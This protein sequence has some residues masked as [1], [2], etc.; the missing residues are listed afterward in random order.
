MTSS[1][2]TISLLFVPLSG[3]AR[4]GFCICFGLSLHCDF[5]R[6]DAQGTSLFCSSDGFGRK[7]LK[8]A[9]PKSDFA[10]QICPDK[11]YCMQT[12][13]SP[14]LPIHQAWWQPPSHL[15]PQ[16][17]QAHSRLLRDS[18]A[19]TLDG[20]LGNQ[21]ILCCLDV[22]FILFSIV[23]SRHYWPFVGKSHHRFQ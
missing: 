10:N 9:I 5:K 16:H 17:I 14:I 4:R 6:H 7:R 22:N 13:T 23:T 8:S 21:C 11:R 1:W 3:P 15:L 2:E 18:N 19:N 12:L 20:I